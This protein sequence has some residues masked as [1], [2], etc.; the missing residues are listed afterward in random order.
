MCE[1]RYLV[2]LNSLAIG[3]IFY[4]IQSARKNCS[5]FSHLY[6]VVKYTFLPN[7]AVY[8]T[9]GES[10][11]S[12][13][14]TSS[15]MLDCN[16]EEVDTRVVMLILHALKQGIKLIVVHTLDTDVII[17]LAG[18]FFE[19]TGNTLV[20]AR[21]SV[22][23][24][25]ILSALT[26]VRKKHIK[27]YQYFILWVTTFAFRGKGQKSAWQAWQA[28]EEVTETFEFLAT[29]PFQNLNSDSEHFQRL[30]VV[31]YSKLVPSLL[32]M[33]QEKSCFVTRTG[34]WT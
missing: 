10:V 5:P 16:H 23:V 8:V 17:I 28:Y 15:M 31:L 33:K 27:H 9:S 21:I 2:K 32:L 26:L 20:Q 11:V 1:E 13:G 34:K 4:M 7:K 29:H 6:K 3:Q 14:Q 19:L 25:L 22:C 18:V 12:V 24:A 30:I